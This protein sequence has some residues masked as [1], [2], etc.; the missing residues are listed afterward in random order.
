MENSIMRSL[1]RLL[2]LSI[3]AISFNAQ[4]SIVPR[5]PSLNK[6]QDDFVRYIESYKTPQFFDE[7][8]KAFQARLKLLDQ[9]PAGGTVKIMTF[10]FDNGIVTRTLAAHMCLAT[11]RGVKVQFTADSKIGDRPG[12]DD[13]FDNTDDHQV[14]EEVF[15][16]LANCGVDVRIHNHIPNFQELSWVDKRVPLINE[17]WFD[18][19]GGWLGNL[20]AKTRL[21]TGYVLAEA[22]AAWSLKSMVGDLKNIFTEEINKL[23]HADRV[24][25]DEVK[26]GLFSLLDE[27]VDNYLSKRKE[28]ERTE[29]IMRVIGQVQERIKNSKIINKVKAE[30]VRPL[31]YNI[32][33]R[34]QSHPV[35]GQFYQQARYFNRLN[36]RKLFWVESQGRSCMFMGGRNIGDHYLTWGRDDHEFMDGDVLFCNQ[37]MKSG[38]ANVMAQSRES[39]DQIFEN[40]DLEDPLNVKPILTHVKRDLRFQYRYLLFNTVQ[41][42]EWGNATWP[43]RPIDK[44]GRLLQMNNIIS[45]NRATPGFARSSRTIPILT[46]WSDNQAVTG[47]T[48]SDSMNW[49]VRTSTW[50]RSKDHVRAE[51]FQAIDNEQ[52]LVYIETAYSE[53]SNKMKDHI[54]AAVQRGVPVHIVTNSIYVS[55]AGSKA[56]RLVMARWTRVMLEKYPTLFK[57]KF[58]TLGFGHMIHFKGASFA[59]QKSGDRVFRLNLV[60]SHNF[61]GRSGYSDKEHAVIWE[62][63]VKAACANKI[64]AKNIATSEAT[65]LKDYRDNFYKRVTA[66]A[67]AKN[68]K[69]IPLKEFKTLADEIEDARATGKLE[70]TRDKIAMLMLTSL[71]EIEKGA[72]GEARA[73]R[74]A[75][76]AVLRIQDQFMEFLE[77]LSESGVSDIIGTLL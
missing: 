62:Q 12:I 31:L 13:A 36:H 69:A 67:I 37:H 8:E 47:R 57:V 77:T 3:S 75:G 58:A 9:V 66:K 4:A 51:L 76:Q 30:K 33:K 18:P 38:D 43:V 42:P 54:E 40:K 2:I 71:Y 5:H 64:G 17:G 14:N 28:L 49:R 48:I 24:S 53:F 46:T 29:N 11:K 68:P 73:K 27:A 70:G 25:M 74:V 60:G 72:N 63:P 1:A 50:N 59:C 16:M 7:N 10:M 55:D 6:T 39:F 41:T 56:I 22:G 21:A 23:P 32:V 52:Q 65:D 35:L 20:G 19:A 44:S 61:H 34:V 15:Q 26:K 45:N